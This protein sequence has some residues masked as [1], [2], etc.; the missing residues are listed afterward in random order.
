MA[1]YSETNLIV[2]YLP[3]D[4]SDEALYR[5]FDS[6]A[7]GVKSVKICRN[8]AT[9]YSYGY[10][11]CEYASRE[12]ALRA[13]DC[14]NGHPLGHK[15]LKVAFAR[16]RS[17][18]TRNCK[19][20]ISCLPIGITEDAMR[21]VL[22]R[23]GSII[24]CRL[25]NSQQQQQQQLPLVTGR[26]LLGFCLFET[27][28]SAQA[29]LSDLHNRPWPGMEA[30]GSEGTVQ[31]RFADENEKK[32]RAPPPGSGRGGGSSGG[33][34]YQ[35]QQQQQYQQHHQQHQQYQQQAQHQQYFRPYTR[36]RGGGSGGSG[37]GHQ[38]LPAW[39]SNDAGGP[40]TSNY[41]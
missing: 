37:G 19:L 5:L 9:G 27:H 32:V 7:P 16:M 3:Q 12:A 40:P 15:T 41:C 8:N 17:E 13:I 39:Y 25:L 35:Q 31:V 34:P 14:L 20:H 11:F 22:S 28:S 10:G 21:S 36:Q 2:N 6:R 29:A 38:P 1:L 26:G 23:Y 4:L 33:R 18:E 30:G 24:N